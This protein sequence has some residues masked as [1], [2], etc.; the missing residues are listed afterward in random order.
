MREWLMIGREE[1]LPNSGDFMTF[2]VCEE[3]I[4]ICR[5]KSGSLNAFYNM[6][7]HR[8]VEVA[9]GSGNTQRF[10]CPYHGWVYDHE[11]RLKGAAH[12]KDSDEFDPA[13]CRLKPVRLATWR[14][15][16]FVCFNEDTRPFD[17]AIA[18]FEKDFGFLQM[19]RCRLGNKIVLELDCNWKFVNENIMDLYH[20]RVLHAGTFGANFSWDNDNVKLRDRG[21]I[22]DLVQCCAADAEW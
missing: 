5:D 9:E 15:N 19:E 22:V 1:E 11:G 21:R 14:G 16:I 17:E 8:G 2:R 7:V 13:K 6:C 10:M 12:M 3:P 20:V 18:P 4:V